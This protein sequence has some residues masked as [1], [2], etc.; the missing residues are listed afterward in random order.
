MQEKITIALP[1]Q[2][3]NALDDVTRQDRVDV[4]QVVT[5][6]I[7]EYLFFRRLR[8]L[9]DRMTSQARARG[10]LSEQDVFDTVS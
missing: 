4:T 1:E 6:A 3:R 9:Q 10:V 5:R 7:E 8:L 2:T